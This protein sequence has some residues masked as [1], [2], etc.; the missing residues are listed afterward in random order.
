MVGNGRES[1]RVGGKVGWPSE[2]T[3]VERTARHDQVEQE[4]A[5]VPAESAWLAIRISGDD[6]SESPNGN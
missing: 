2:T 3:R 6:S 4:E 5:R 1:I